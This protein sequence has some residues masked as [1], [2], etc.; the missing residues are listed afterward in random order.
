MS[1]RA[2]LKMV[3]DMVRCGV[4]IADIGTDHGYL[5][6]WLVRSGKCI[7]GVAADLR[8]SPL[9]N[10]AETLRIYQVEDKISLRLSDGLDSVYKEECDDIVLAGMG[11]TLIVELLARTPW[12]FDK[13][14]RIIAQPMTHSE[15]VRKFFCENGFEI[16]SENACHDE[17]RD[18]IAICAR[19]N[20]EKQTKNPLYYYIGCHPMENNEA[21][22]NYAERQIK[23]VKTRSD[24]LNKAGIENEESHLLNGVLEEFKECKKWQE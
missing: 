2:R 23:R 20:G 15:D 9:E 10:A 21:S 19:Y 17:G 1:L 13:S 16:L 5:P 6:A 4:K 24:A 8:K 7:G 11:G 14:K 12:I 22:L 18:Y 3:A